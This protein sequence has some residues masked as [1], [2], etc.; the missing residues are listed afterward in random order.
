MNKSK[1]LIRI[2]GNF[3]VSFFSPLVG[4]NIAETMFDIGF[5]FEQIIIIALFS[6]IFVTGLSISKE[7]VEWSQ[8]GKKWQ[9]KRKKQRKELVIGY[10]KYFHAYWFGKGY[11]M[12]F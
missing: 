9:E 6:A 10:M 11:I 3:G 5:T 4:G 12:V 1:G 8:N 7:A 2:F